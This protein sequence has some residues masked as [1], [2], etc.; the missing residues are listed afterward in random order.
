MSAWLAYN[1]WWLE[2]MLIPFSLKLSDSISETTYV[3]FGVGSWSLVPN[4]RIH[5]HPTVNST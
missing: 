3:F 5:L 1:P 2:I 4:G